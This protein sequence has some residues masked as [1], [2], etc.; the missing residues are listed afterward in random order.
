MLILKQETETRSISGGG[1]ECQPKE[2]V[3]ITNNLHA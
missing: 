3:G 1:A 2:K